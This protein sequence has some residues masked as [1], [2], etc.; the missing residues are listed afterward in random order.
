M[1]FKPF[2]DEANA[3]ETDRACD[4]FESAWQSNANPR[5]EDFIVESSGD[6]RSAMLRQLVLLDWNSFSFSVK[7][8]C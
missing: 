1:K 5:I 2:V 4:R 6:R 3:R 7:T 8:I